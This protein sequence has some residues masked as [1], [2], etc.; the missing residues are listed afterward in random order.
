MTDVSKILQAYAFAHKAH[1]GQKRWDGSEYINHPQSVVEILQNWGI[2]DENILCA[3]ML[4]DVVEDTKITLEEIDAGFGSKVAGYVRE[5]TNPSHSQHYLEK[6]AFMSKGA[7]IIKM[8]DLIHNLSDMKGDKRTLPKKEEAFIKRM[9]A[10]HI[11]S[12]RM[13]EFDTTKKSK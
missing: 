12:G 5:L 7:T 3:G 8:A 2:E 6:I 11:L 10:L 13:I 1:N 9:K 4:H